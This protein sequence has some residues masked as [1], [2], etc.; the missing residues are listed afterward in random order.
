[1]C[2]RDSG[3]GVQSFK[4]LNGKSILSSVV[5]L[6]GGSGYENKQRS[7]ES[8]GI[9][10]ALSIIN[11]PSHDYK[12][13]EI[14]KYS[15]DGT[16]IDGLSTDKQYYVSVVNK[17]QF[18][19]A[20]VGV[21]TTASSFYINSR[22]FNEFRSTGVGTHTFNYPPISVE[23]IGRVGVSSISGNTFEASLQPIFRGEITSLQLTNT[24]VGYGASEIVDFNRVPEINLNTGR[25]AVITPV[26]SNGRIVDVSVRYGWTEYNSPPDLVELGIF[27]DA[28]LTP[29]MNSSGNITSVNIESSGIGYGITTTTVRVDASG[30]DLSLI[31]IWRCRRRG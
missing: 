21:G 12:T 1:M 20:A 19:L 23:V 18:K 7:C 2:I 22:Q 10:T 16:T 8:T 29:I 6:D 3:S 11:I 13:G 24:G 26:V 17:D 27:S 31:H 28:R 4:S 15:V 9:S 5:V 30:K 14:V 25:D